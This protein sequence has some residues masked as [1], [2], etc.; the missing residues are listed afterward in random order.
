M[1]L[2]NPKTAIKNAVHLI[3]E[4]S[5]KRKRKAFYGQFISMNE[6]YFD[7]GANFG[8]R[9][10][11]I[12]ELGAKIIAV[13]PQ[14]ACQDSLRAKYGTRITIVGKALD[15]EEGVQPIYVSNASTLTTLS[16]EFIA[17]TQ[18]SGRFSEYRWDRTEEVATTTLD[19]MI[20]EHGAPRFIKIDVEGY[21][22]NVLQGL[23][24]K[25]AYLSIEYAVPEMT[26]NSL[27]CI[28][29][30][31]TIGEIRLNYSVGETMKLELKEWLTRDEMASLIKT[32]EFQSTGFGDIY[33]KFI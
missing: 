14:K 9:I 15:K 1:N 29:Y 25:V 12:L 19:R 30:L 6:V 4:L 18:E 24:Q 3:K 11:P 26:E 10:E 2:T 33:I 28:N 13:E 8:N 20:E 32:K 31:T 27:K 22:Y 17:K 7:I 21:E 16:K 5:A 23:T